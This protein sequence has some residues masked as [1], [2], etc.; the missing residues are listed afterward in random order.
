[1]LWF[2]TNLTFIDNTSLTDVQTE[3]INLDCILMLRMTIILYNI[4]IASFMTSFRTTTTA[5]VV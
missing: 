3:I 2:L 1:M 5:R 4:F